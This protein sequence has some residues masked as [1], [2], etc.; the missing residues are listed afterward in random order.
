MIKQ[1][2]IDLGSKNAPV[3]GPKVCTPAEGAK[4]TTIPE[5]MT[6]TQTKTRAQIKDLPKN[7]RGKRNS[8]TRSD[9]EFTV[10][11]GSL[12]PE[13]TADSS[14]TT[15]KEKKCGRKVRQSVKQTGKTESDSQVQKKAECFMGKVKP[16]APNKPKMAPVNE[17]VFPDKTK[18][19]EKLAEGAAETR[20]TANKE[21]PKGRVARGGRKKGLDSI[22]RETLEK[23]KIRKT[24][25][26]EA[27]T[28]VNDVVK[29]ILKHLKENSKP[30]K[31]AEQL[32]TG[33]YYE[34]LKVSVFFFLPS[35]NFTVHYWVL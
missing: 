2:N 5:E 20:Q 22:L 4:C 35:K 1:Q 26:S 32:N 6:E 15:T 11:R 25:R 13:D 28:V 29:T 10:E 16:V 9:V 12:P 34:N 14:L 17:E 30:F 24:K 19:P 7:T 8:R 31:D 33:S 23:E 27:A 18:P 21:P 3:P